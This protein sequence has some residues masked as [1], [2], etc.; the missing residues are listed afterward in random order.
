M[1]TPPTPGG[2]RRA[3]LATLAVLL[4]AL[5]PA[6]APHAASV[7]PMG[8][9][10]VIDDA[11]IVFQGRALENRSA[12]EASGEVVTYTTFQVEEPLKGPVGAT[13]TIKQIGGRAGDRI[14]RVDG[15]PSFTPGQRYVI[16]LYGV[17]AQGFS[18]PVGLAQGRFD[19]VPRDGRLRGRQRARFPRAAGVDPGG[20][21][22]PTVRARLGA[23]SSRV[24][25]LELGEFKRLVRE[26]AGRR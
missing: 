11:A 25:R 20:R 22:P 6:V 13:H 7:R 15:I 9:D 14:Y 24:E 4:V 10:A 8:F 21:L 26:R 23:K 16:F 19:I 1:R 17:S 18:S 3:T 5:F 12:V 2:F